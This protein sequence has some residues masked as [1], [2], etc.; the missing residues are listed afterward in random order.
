[1]GVSAANRAPFSGAFR[2]TADATGRAPVGLLGGTFDPVHYG[3]LAIAEQ[4][5]EALGL[6]GVLFIPAAR[7]PHK[8]DQPITDAQHRVAMVELAIA[9]A[10]SFLLGRHEL[11]RPGPSYS[12]DT[13]SEV[14]RWSAA[15]GHP[16]PVFILSAEALAGLPGW[17]DSQ[18]LL[19]S[20]RI[21]VVPRRGYPVPS[22][23]WLD[24]RFPG[25][26]DRFVFMAGPDLGHSASDIRAR[27]AAGRSIRYLVPPAVERYIQLHQLYRPEPDQKD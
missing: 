2:A 5:R 27:V 3:H 22:P 16:E 12:A 23:A 8:L 25:F 18:R 6:Q 1:V 10:D 17:H 26:A 7:P 24:E 11:D 21:A 20:C 15:E 9:D 14:A 13:V 4:T 19:R